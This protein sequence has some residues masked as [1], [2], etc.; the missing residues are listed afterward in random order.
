MYGMPR[1]SFQTVSARISR[2]HP[3][4]CQFDILCLL[5]ISVRKQRMGNLHEEPGRDL[6]FSKKRPEMLQG[7]AA[8]VGRAEEAPWMRQ[9]YDALNACQNGKEPHNRLTDLTFRFFA[10]SA[11]VG[12]WE[13]LNKDLPG[14]GEGLLN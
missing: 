14:A 1:S 6:L 10:V 3:G 9:V 4:E 2:I 11:E 8:R 13:K 12:V 5:A 7:L